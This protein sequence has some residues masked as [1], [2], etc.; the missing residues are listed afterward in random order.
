M[1]ML[2]LLSGSTRLLVWDACRLFGPSNDISAAQQKMIASL[3]LG[4]Y[5]YELISLVHSCHSAAVLNCLASEGKEQT[6]AKCSSCM[7]H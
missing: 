6:S 7:P 3:V 1:G 5:Y 4:K 2:V